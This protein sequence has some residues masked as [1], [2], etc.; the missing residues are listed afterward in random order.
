MIYVSNYLGL[1]LLV[2]QK[3]WRHIVNVAVGLVK[4]LFVWQYLLALNWASRGPEFVEFLLKLLLT[5]QNL[6]NAGLVLAT[7]R[8]INVLLIGRHWGPLRR[9]L[10]HYDK[11]ELYC[12]PSQ[13][14]HEDYSLAHEWIFSFSA[15]WRLA[16]ALIQSY[17]G[18]AIRP[19]WLNPIVTLASGSWWS[20]DLSC[21]SSSSLS[22]N[23]SRK[24]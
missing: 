19:V 2:V 9:G 24:K 3:Q 7:S 22:G 4:N 1:R 8:R 14:A 18:D 16:I 17:L 13:L 15:L 5:I 20:N 12:I 23:S 11:R 21:Y 6:Y 10:R